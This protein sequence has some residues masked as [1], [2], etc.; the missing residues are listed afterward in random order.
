[1]TSPG[2][3]LT[4]LFFQDIRVQGCTMGFAR[5]FR[6]MLRFVEHADLHPVIDSVVSGLDAAPEAFAKMI[7][8]DVFGKIVIEL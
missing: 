3:E 6:T 4:R 1:M 8:G 2:A 7:A 5:G